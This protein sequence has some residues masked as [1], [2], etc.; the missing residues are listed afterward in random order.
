MMISFPLKFQNFRLLFTYIHHCLISFSVFFKHKSF[1]L[2]WACSC[3]AFQCFGWKI[4]TSC[5]DVRGHSWRCAYFCVKL[6]FIAGIF[7]KKYLWYMKIHFQYH[8]FAIWSVSA[9]FSSIIAWKAPTSSWSLSDLG[10]LQK[11]SIIAHLPVLQN[12]KTACM[13]ITFRVG[14]EKTN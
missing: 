10:K 11:Q 6:A 4:F 7:L 5:P 8:V 2:I 13:R 12:L 14:L 1:L 3:I 9:S